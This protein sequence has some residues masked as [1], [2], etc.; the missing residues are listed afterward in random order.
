[1]GQND[2]KRTQGLSTMATKVLRSIAITLIVFAVVKLLF[3]NSG[4]KRNNMKTVI[5]PGTFWRINLE[6]KVDRMDPFKLKEEVKPKIIS[7]VPQVNK[8]D[9]ADAVKIVHLDLKGAAPKVNYLEQIF[10]LLSS[11]GAD[12]ILLEYEDMFPYY[13]DLQILRSPYAYSMEDIEKIKSLAKLNKLDIIP[14]VQVF[15]HLEFVLKH[16]QYFP[17]REVI[18]LP[19]DLNPHHP[20]SVTLVKSMVSQVMA[21]H[22]EATWFHM[23]ADEV[24]GLGTG[25]DSKNWLQGNKGG[26]D[27]MFLKHTVEM[28]C[29]ISEKRPGLRVLMC[30]SGLQNFAIPTIWNYGS[31]VDTDVIGNLISRYESAGFQ[32]LWFASA[33]K[34]ASLINQIWT[35]LEHHLQNHLSWLIVMTYMFT[36]YPSI[37]LKG[38]MLTGWQRYEHHTVLCEL[39]PVGIPSLA[40]CLLTLKH[41]SFGEKAQIEAHHIL[42]C[43][44][45]VEENVC[46]GSVAFAGSQIYHRVH[47]IHTLLKA[48]VNK[49]MDN[50]FIKGGFGRYQRRHNFAN[51]RHIEIFHNE[52]KT[53]LD[54]WE[55]YIEDFRVEMG[56]IFFTDAV[57]EGMEENVN[58]ELDIMRECAEDA[59]R[60]LKLNGQPKSL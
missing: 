32:S 10:P 48:E 4:T 57:E 16:K 25:E 15:G 42:G 12:G 9:R 39:F 58:T 14:L 24:F 34:G 47:T 51:P 7:A 40:M 30:M 17:L 49:L 41:G 3:F 38:I 59:E 28:A 20:D 23:G 27:Q 35:P 19:N 11:L 45:E 18:Q 6:N 2:P 22:P 53:L 37:A 36:K 43:K 5:D 54:K 56:A 13:G 31:S 44:I 52:L 60:I 33:F 55:T 1:M 21:C 8:S 26:V 46:K 50:F 29:F